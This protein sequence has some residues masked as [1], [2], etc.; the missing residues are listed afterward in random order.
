MVNIQNPEN[1]KG[2]INQAPTDSAAFFWEC[3]AM[4]PAV[5]S[6]KGIWNKAKHLKRAEAV[7]HAYAKERV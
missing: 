5:N 7:F 6:H 2:S 4:I 1:I 3:L